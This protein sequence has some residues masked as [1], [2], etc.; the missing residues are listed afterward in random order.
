M[1]SLNTGAPHFK[2]VMKQHRHANYTLSKVLNEFIDNVIKKTNEIRIFT[3]IDDTEKLQEIRVSDNY[4]NGFDNLD[5]EGISNPF[6]MGHIKAAHDDD[7]ETSEFGVG[8]KAGALAAANQL[9]VYTKIRDSNGV[10]KFVEVICDFIRMA[11][12]PDVNASYNPRIKH[13]T[14]EEYREQHPFDFG[15]TLKLSKIR[16][17]IYSKTTQDSIT[18]DISNSISETYSRFISKQNQIYVNGELVVPNYDFFEDPKCNPFTISKELFILEKSGIYVFLIKKTKEIS[19]WQEFNKQTSKWTKLKNHHNGNEYINELIKSGY[20][21]NYIPLNEEGTCMYINTTFTFYSDKYHTSKPKSE[22]DLPEDCVYIYKD[23]RNYGKQSLLKHNNGVHNYTLHELDFVSKRLGK[24]LGI[25]FNKEILMNGNNDII[26]VVKSA[27]VDSREE[28]TADTHNAKN[29]RLCEKAI[30]LKLIDLSTCPE[31]KL[32]ADHR[33]KRERLKSPI[34]QEFYVKPP[35]TV[36]Q[37]KPIVQVKPVVPTIVP[38]LSTI[39]PVVSTN[40]SNEE[41][42]DESDNDST[43][44]PVQIQYNSSTDIKNETIDNSSNDLRQN[45]TTTEDITK[46]LTENIDHSNYDNRK[47]RTMNIMYF[48]RNTITGAQDELLSDNVLNHIEQILNIN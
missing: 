31:Q 32:S 11:N 47:K 19:V 21:H 36:T 42:S 17:S 8:M 3:Q 29:A 7:S 48:L 16:D 12:E 4:I 46:D 26:S 13:I 2:S 38:V 34:S 6:N 35:Q 24:D 20:K 40:I 41:S 23:D 25:T 18:R 39:V 1:T 44:S 5:S 27:L 14:Y 15:S 28:F 10:Y 43:N 33:T 37:H 9:N 30:K 22:P 45:E